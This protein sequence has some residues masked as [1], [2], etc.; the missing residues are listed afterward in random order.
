[1][2]AQGLLPQRALAS[3]KRSAHYGRASMCALMGNIRAKAPPAHP[4]SAWPSSPLA[5][6]D[7]R[8]GW[9]APQLLTE[10]PH[11]GH[12]SGT[13]RCWQQHVWRRSRNKK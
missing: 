13:E 2:I 3:R 10:G 1:M 12:I 11:L 5:C 6:G 8:R 7:C 9:P 4:A